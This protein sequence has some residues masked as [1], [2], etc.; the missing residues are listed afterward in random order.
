MPRIV[1]GR[2]RF[3][4]LCWSA[5][6]ITVDTSTA[7]HQKPIFLLEIGATKR[8]KSWPIFCGRGTVPSVQ[9]RNEVASMSLP[10][11]KNYSYP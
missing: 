6:N 4:A 3:I 5:S 8:Q 11:S 1:S 10:G 2:A 7:L 9:T